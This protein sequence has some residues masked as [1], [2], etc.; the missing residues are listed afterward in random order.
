MRWMAGD[1]NRAFHDPIRVPR[2][3]S[4]GGRTNAFFVDFYRRVAADLHGLEAREHTAQVPYANAQEREERFREGKLPILYCSPTM[5]LGVDIARPERG[6]YAQCAADARELRAAERARGAQRPARAGLLLLH[7]RQPARPVLLQ[8]SGTDGR[9]CG[10]PRPPRPGERGPGP[11][12]CLRHLARGDRN[13]GARALA[14]QSLKILDLSG[15]PPALKVLD[16][17]QAATGRLPCP[18]QGPGA[19]GKGPDDL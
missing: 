2:Q 14:R 18:L 17:V 9:R 6:Q 4:E 16:F 7:H 3:P 12:A 5:E 1:G 13:R 15:E 8:T 19:R 10:Q 11:R